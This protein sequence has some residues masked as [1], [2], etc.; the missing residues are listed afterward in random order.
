MRT[1]VFEQSPHD[2]IEAATNALQ[3]QGF[4]PLTS[5]DLPKVYVPL[6]PYYRI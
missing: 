1:R 5:S 3:E 4:Q 2:T 6:P